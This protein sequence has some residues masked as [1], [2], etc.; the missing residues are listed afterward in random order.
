MSLLETLLTPFRKIYG[1]FLYEESSR[2]VA[3]FRIFI[4]ISV[5]LTVLSWSNPRLLFTDAGY[6]PTDLMQ[7]LQGP[8]RFS[9][10]FFLRNPTAIVA[11]YYLLLIATICFIFGILSRIANLVVFVLFL[12]FIAR[13]SILGYGGTS[14]LQI[15]LFYSLFLQTDQALV[16]KF[17]RPKKQPAT[18]PGWPLRLIQLQ[19]AIVYISAATLKL[20]SLDWVHGTI[21]FSVLNNPS[22][23]YFD[24]TPLARF[25][26]IF[27]F[28]TYFTLVGELSFIYWVWIPSHR[29]V[30]LGMVAM[31]HIGLLFTLNVH[32]FSEIMLC[33]LTAFL[34]PTEA[35]WVIARA[36][37]L[38]NYLMG[39]LRIPKLLPK[40]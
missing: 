15:I 12:S 17:A 16:P 37:S 27:I 36:K 35:D 24:F 11:C 26:W 23:S 40:T 19:I 2:K 22:F 18:V 20:Q 38:W 13:N 39:L 8:L 30:A 28:L 7:T 3:L 10:F 4:G 34:I 32:Y 25:P 9:L 1:F 21:L 33:S 14:I 5:L 31:L 29:R 6:F